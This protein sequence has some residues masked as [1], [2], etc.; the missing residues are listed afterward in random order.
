MLN[1]QLEVPVGELERLALAGRLVID[2][3]LVV[4]DQQAVT[5]LPPTGL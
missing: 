5:Q 4:L 2:P 1:E 3:E